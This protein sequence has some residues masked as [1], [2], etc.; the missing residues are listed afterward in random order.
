MKMTQGFIVMTTNL[1][2]FVFGEPTCDRED[3]D[4]KQKLY[5]FFRGS[6]LLVPFHAWAS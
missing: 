6:K 2:L 3:F 4:E 5:Y 1:A